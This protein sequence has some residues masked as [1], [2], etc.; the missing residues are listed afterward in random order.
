MAN[1]LMAQRV[2]R[3][4][5]ALERLAETQARAEE[6]WGALDAA[7][8]R[9]TEAQRRTEEQLTA[10]QARTEERLGRLEEQTGALKDALARLAAAQARTVERLD[11]RTGGLEAAV[12][13]LARQVGGLSETV[14]GDIED[15]AYIVL[16]DVLQREF[17]W[18]VGV[19]E[20]SFQTWNGRPE[21]VNVFGQA[22]DP[23]QPDKTIWIVGE[24]KHNLTLS[25]VGRSARQVER[26]R[27][28]LVGDLFPVC[29]CY[30]ARPEVQAR[31]RTQGLRLVFSYGRLV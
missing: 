2:D 11:G 18:Q 10:A 12:G 22:K 6:Q 28:H 23:A 7:L 19:L 30:R 25:E 26:A 17:G 4:E 9:L 13:Q 29:F 5:A 24:A 14:G 8:E 21:E 15:I 31:I 27:R 16:H 1:E 3:L 20:R